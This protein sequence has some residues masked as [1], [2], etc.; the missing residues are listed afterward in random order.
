MKEGKDISE[1]KMDLIPMVD[2]AINIV[3]LLFERGESVGVSE[4]AGALNLPKAN[5]Y[6]ILLTMQQR[7]YI[8]KEPKT[9]KYSLGYS[10][11]KIGEYV[12]KN[13]DIR[14]TAA[15]YMEKLAKE[16][17]E[18]AYLCKLHNN[19]AL[20]VETMDGEA[21]ALYS[22]VEAAVPLYCSALG[23]ALMA[24][25]DEEEI[26]AYIA[27]KGMVKRTISTITTKKELMQAIKRLKETG[28]CIEV[29][30]Y[31]YGMM[32]IAGT[33]RNAAGEV[34]GSMSVSGPTSR[35]RHKGEAFVIE[36]VKEACEDISRNIQY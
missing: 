16:T 25:F 19:E 3:E 30:E 20:I 12:K 14:K 24:D 34:I 31:E 1:V 23:R 17:G 35:I 21:S 27:E 4:I 22:M 18:T 11:I 13:V 7:G 6:R 9:D 5:V 32:C 29:E 26:D 8:E 33:L 15:P 10:F 28:V 2:R 36:K